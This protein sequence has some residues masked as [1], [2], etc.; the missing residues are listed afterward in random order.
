VL[1]HFFGNDRSFV[2]SSDGLPEVTRSFSNFDAALDEVANARV[3]G[4]IHFRTA[5]RDAQ[6]AGTALGKY[7]ID[8]AFR[9]VGDGDRDDDDDPID[10]RNGSGRERGS[11]D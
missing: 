11:D 7:I 3:F 9:R 2:I 6:A 8:N 5:T 4:G 10:D 1:A